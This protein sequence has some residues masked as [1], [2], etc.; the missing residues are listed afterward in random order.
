MNHTNK[1]IESILISFRINVSPNGKIE[2]YFEINE[3][4]E[5][6]FES[7]FIWFLIYYNHI[8]GLKIINDDSFFIFIINKRIK[9]LKP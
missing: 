9:L 6:K 4:V 1:N 5:I 7:P 2:I 3:S 8:I